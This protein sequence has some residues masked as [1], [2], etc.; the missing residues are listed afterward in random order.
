[1]SINSFVAVISRNISTTG[2]FY[3][4]LLESLSEEEDTIVENSDDENIETNKSFMKLSASRATFGSLVKWYEEI[5]VDNTTAI[6]GILS[7]ISYFFLF[8]EQISGDCCCA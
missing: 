4:E 2:Q 1:M 3:K 5:E 7:N 6:F 8:L